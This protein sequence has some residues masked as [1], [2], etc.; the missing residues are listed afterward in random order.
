MTNLDIILSGE[1]G[2]TFI[3]NLIFENCNYDSFLTVECYDEEID[4]LREYAEN[5]VI[6]FVAGD[7]DISKYSR[8][9]DM[10]SNLRS[11][12]FNVSAIYQ[13]TK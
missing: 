10:I 12:G 9:I 3:S 1:S 7:K 2:K 13:V 6:N 8:Y 11:E 4:K 5:G